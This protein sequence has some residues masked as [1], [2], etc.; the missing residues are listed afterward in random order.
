EIVYIEEE[1]EINVGFDTYFYLPE[2]FNPYQ[3]MKISLD[4]IHYMECEEEIHLDFNVDDFLPK[5][6]DPF[7]RP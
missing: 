2:G 5:D 4:D 1:E 6:F 7:M 3:G